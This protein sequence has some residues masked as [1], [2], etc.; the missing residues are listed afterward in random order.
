VKQALTGSMR[1]DI[2]GARSARMPS[3]SRV[4]PGRCASDHTPSWPGKPWPQACT[5]AAQLITMPKPPRARIVSQRYSSSPSVP[6]A[7]LC[8]FVSGASSMRLAQAGPWRIG[9]GAARA[10]GGG[11]GILSVLR[12]VG[13]RGR[14]G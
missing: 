2:R 7:W 11:M 5:C 4:S 12:S 3:A 14:L 10:T 6:S 9:K 1:I 13:G 8:Q